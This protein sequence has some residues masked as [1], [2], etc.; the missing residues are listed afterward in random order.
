MND[1]LALSESLGVASLSFRAN[2]HCEAQV[3]ESVVVL[4][5]LYIHRLKRLNKLQGQPGSEYLVAICS[6]MLYVIFSR[7]TL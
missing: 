7:S 3:S 2:A 6:L 4:A 1:V 5:L